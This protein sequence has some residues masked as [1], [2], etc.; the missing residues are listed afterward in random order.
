MKEREWEK[1]FVGRDAPLTQMKAAWHAAKA[2]GPQLLT[3]LAEPGF[4]KTRLVQ[5]FYRWLS[6]HEQSIPSHQYWPKRLGKRVDN[7]LISPLAQ[8]CQIDRQMRFLWLGF[9]LRDPGNRNEVLGSA[10]RQID[11]NLKPHLFNYQKLER[12]RNLN[13][14]RRGAIGNAG[15]EA[16]LAIGGAI[17]AIGTIFSLIGAGKSLRSSI[18]E[19]SELNSG[20]RSASA[21]EPSTGN[22]LLDGE[23]DIVDL[24]CHDLEVVFKRPPSGID[25]LPG[26]IVIDDAQWLDTDPTMPILVQRLLARAQMDDWPLLV[27]VSS[28]E[29]EWNER[30]GSSVRRHLVSSGIEETRIRLTRTEGLEELVVAAYQGLN[31]EQVTS[32]TEMCDGNVQFLIEVLKL[33]ERNPKLFKER[34]LS[35]SLQDNA[36]ET[37]SKVE[38]ENLVLGRIQ[39]SPDHVQKAIGLA[40]LQGVSFSH[41][42]VLGLAKH[43]E[44]ERSEK[45]LEEAETPHSLVT[46]TLDGGGEFRAR[47]YHAAARENAENFLNVQEATKALLAIMSDS[48]FTN[49]DQFEREG[50]ASEQELEARLLLLES[51]AP[52]ERKVGF[53][54]LAMLIN[55]AEERDD[56]RSS[57][58]LSEKW[59]RH[60]RE[61]S[62]S[63]GPETISVP[64]DIFVR[65]SRL[66]EAEE[67][68]RA[69]VDVS[70]AMDEGSFAAWTLHNLC[71]TYSKVGGLKR[72]AGD[73]EGALETSKKAL[74]HREALADW[75]KT[76]HSKQVLCTSLNEVGSLLA[77]MGDQDA[78]LKHHRRALALSESLIKED[79]SILARNA[80]FLS[81][82][83]IANTFQEMG[84]EEEAIAAYE[85]AVALAEELFFETDSNQGRRAFGSI[86]RRSGEAMVRFGRTEDGNDLLVRAIAVYKRLTADT[87]APD[88]F[89]AL[90][91][92]Y[93]AFAKASEIDG[94]RSQSLQYY[95]Q[96]LELFSRIIDDHNLIKDYYAY[97]T[98]SNPIIFK[99]VKRFKFRDAFNLFRR[100]NELSR[101][102]IDALLAQ[103]MG[104]AEI[105]KALRTGSGLGFELRSSEVS[106][107]SLRA[108]PENLE[109]QQHLPD[110]AKPTAEMSGPISRNSL[111]PCGSGKR[112]K[113]CHGTLN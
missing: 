34:N 26:V 72:S 14:K 89:R 98:H 15:L 99:H 53:E 77:A 100:R 73:I 82:A 5:E 38:F 18:V 70:E 60:W 39:S 64:F 67:L 31:P 44:I 21:S 111:C 96:G 49:K 20:I 97:L 57:L 103:G 6:D 104:L 71:V 109:V 110:E 3:V 16:G 40:A 25:P 81:T 30:L 80:L 87:G 95:V 112:F 107:N 41:D 52:P 43:L 33:L 78:S 13:A 56:L 59:L 23:I 11:E 19:I 61:N 45:G 29:R 62:V 24:V 2:N 85:R 84:Q 58:A 37:I 35:A 102:L 8:D 4:G 113:Q 86:L 93:I 22:A 105:T 9:R 65:F 94:Q 32:I 12:L 88:D 74:E 83:N 28:W 76:I 7:L 36:I 90:A 75:Q 63:V 1:L 47:F 101:R 55:I 27:I 42:I 69:L 50:I 91:L 68:S 79:S 48:K 10:I 46:H 51:L 17:P 106:L 92:S 54:A 66:G 108:N